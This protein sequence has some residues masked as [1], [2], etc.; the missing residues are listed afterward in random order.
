MLNKGRARD[1]ITPLATDTT[2][3]YCVE[4]PNGTVVT[5]APYFRGLYCVTLDGDEEYTH[6][7]P[8]GNRAEFLEHNHNPF[9]DEMACIWVAAREY[10]PTAP[11]AFPGLKLI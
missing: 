7:T 3:F 1:L 9:F 4:F 2:I 10:G 11:N 5:N 6:L 8:T